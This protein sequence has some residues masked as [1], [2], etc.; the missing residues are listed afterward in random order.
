[1][2]LLVCHFIGSDGLGFASTQV[3]EDDEHIASGYGLAIGIVQI[4][5]AFKVWPIIEE[6][7]LHLAEFYLVL[8]KQLLYD[9]VFPNQ[10]RFQMH[11][12]VY[13]HVIQE[14]SNP[15]QE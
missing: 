9:R 6:N 5:K 10:R 1:M 14:S 3:T 15:G 11:D 13:Y 8:R 2:L 7:L 4:L 12:S